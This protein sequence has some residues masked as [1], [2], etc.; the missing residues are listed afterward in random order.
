MDKHEE[1][2]TN[3]LLNFAVNV[4]R[5]AKIEVKKIGN[6]RGL[7]KVVS[8]GNK[9]YLYQ[10]DKLSKVLLTKLNHLAKANK[11]KEAHENKIDLKLRRSKAL[12]SYAIKYK[13]DISPTH[14]LF[15]Y[16][17]NAFAISNIK[18]KGYRGFT[19]LK[20]ELNRLAI[21]LNG[22]PGIAL[23]VIANVFFSTR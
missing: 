10:P 9:N 7:R 13:A 23:T 12:K 6:M 4:S 19:Y 17:S 3:E 20:Y 5:D 21:L 15:E 22:M 16:Y 8:I 1:S 2:I 11:F 14:S 18:L